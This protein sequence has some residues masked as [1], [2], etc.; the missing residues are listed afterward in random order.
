MTGQNRTTFGSTGG[1]YNQFSSPIGIAI[2]SKDRIYIVDHG[3]HRIVRI[4]DMNGTNWT[5]I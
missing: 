2:D 4:D 1:G 5:T 3:N